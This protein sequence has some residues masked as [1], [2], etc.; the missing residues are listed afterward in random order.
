MY[1]DY[2]EQINNALE[3]NRKP[4]L[5]ALSKLA[6]THVNI[7]YE[8][9]GDSGDVTQIKVTPEKAVKELETIHIEYFSPEQTKNGKDYRYPLVAKTLTLKEALYAFAFQWLCFEHRGWENNEGS[10]GNV[11][12]DVV[13]KSFHLDHLE[14][15]TESYNYE[16]KL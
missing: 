10:S 14:Y 1:I 15:A 16:Y 6:I 12:I 4:L 2:Q 11:E 3:R 5:D 9:C 7:E 13:E 8:G